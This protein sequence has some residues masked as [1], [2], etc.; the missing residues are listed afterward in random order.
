MH[1]CVQLKSDEI[2]RAFE[3]FF[4]VIDASDIE[5]KMH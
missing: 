4:R 2:S 1:L 5:S 3:E